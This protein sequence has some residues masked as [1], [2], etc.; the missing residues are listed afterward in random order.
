MP[1]CENS[2]TD[3]CKLLAI[4]RLTAHDIDDYRRIRLASLQASPEA[5]GA[6]YE[7]TS[8]RPLAFFE[9]RLT[10]CAIYGAYDGAVI[11]GTVCLIPETGPKDR[12]K[13]HLTGMYVAPE[14]RRQGVGARL[15]DALIADANEIVE[16]IMLSVV[17]GNA[18]AITLYERL[19]FVAYGVE[20]RALKVADAYFDEILMVKFLGDRPATSPPSPT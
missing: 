7:A 5:F 3:I 12:H 8:G 14:A 16:Q 19:G 4:R 6:T 18:S 1:C 10:E 13:G 17:V 9:Q 11:V 15:I 20:P 2:S